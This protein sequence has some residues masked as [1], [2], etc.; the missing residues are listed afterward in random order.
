VKPGHAASVPQARCNY[1]SN[2]DLD[3][4]Y[5]NKWKV[6]SAWVGERIEELVTGRIL[7]WGAQRHRVVGKDYATGDTRVAEELF[8]FNAP[9]SKID[10][11][12]DECVGRFFTI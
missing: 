6:P 3:I 12:F 9:R 10:K 1:K 4:R 2:Y 7:W 8:W 11:L 5:M